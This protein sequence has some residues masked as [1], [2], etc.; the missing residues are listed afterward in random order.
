MG[1]SRICETALERIVPEHGVMEEY[2]VEQDFP[3]IGR[4]IM[5]LNARK[6]FYDDDNH[7]TILLAIE[8]ITERRA[9]EHQTRE[10]LLQKDLLLK[11]MR[12]RIANSLQIIASILM[13]KARNVESAETRMHLQEAHKRVLSIA[14][15]QDHL[16]AS[17]RGEPIAVAPYL[18]SLCATLASR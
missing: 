10:L 18:S 6:V 13:L 2:E 4:R 7:T 11:E 16:Q 17:G 3:V 14:A 15:V 5:L 9:A 12:H 1:Y 8:D